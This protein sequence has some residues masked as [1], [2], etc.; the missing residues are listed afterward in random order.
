[1]SED[2]DLNHIISRWSGASTGVVV[3]VF[4][5]ADGGNDVLAVC[6]VD[7]SNCTAPG[8]GASNLLGR[9]RLNNS[10]Y[11]IGDVAFSAT[12]TWNGGAKTFT[13]VLGSCTAGCLFVG[14]GGSSTASFDPK[15]GASDGGIRDLAG[16]AV[17]TT[18]P[19][20]TGL[21]F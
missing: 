8:A 17:Q 9:V 21:H 1:M 4:N 5:D 6:S 16:N 18:N 2:I 14:L 19:T 3:K 12:L 13:V 15:A 7:D 10:L 20:E 11:V